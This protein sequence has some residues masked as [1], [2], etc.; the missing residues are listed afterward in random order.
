[1]TVWYGADG[2]GGGG[3]YYG[4]FAAVEW[5]FVG[6]ADGGDPVCAEGCRTVGVEVVFL[7]GPAG[8]GEGEEDEGC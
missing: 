4:G 5:G 6:D 3:V 2:R 8:R 1:M 7:N